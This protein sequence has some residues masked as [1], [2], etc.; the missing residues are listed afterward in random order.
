M[1][2]ADGVRLVTVVNYGQ[3][4]ETRVGLAKEMTMK[5]Q[6]HLVYHCVEKGFRLELK[7]ILN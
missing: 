4:K 3:R 2:E 6:R 7:Y 5:T 1:F